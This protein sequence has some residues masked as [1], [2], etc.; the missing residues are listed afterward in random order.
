MR[1]VP[2]KVMGNG[3]ATASTGSR[4]GFGDARCCSTCLKVV[5]SGECLLSVV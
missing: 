5:F 4:D 3:L 1:E 2:A